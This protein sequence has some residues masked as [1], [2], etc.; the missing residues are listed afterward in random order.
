MYCIAS[1]AYINMLEES[2]ITL[3]ASKLLTSS[4]AKQKNGVC[5]VLCCGWRLPLNDVSY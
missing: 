1:H 2:N 5:A 3:I 4:Q